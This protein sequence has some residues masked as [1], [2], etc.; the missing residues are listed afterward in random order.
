[1]LWDLCMRGPDT[2][3]WVQEIFLPDLNIHVLIIKKWKGEKHFSNVQQIYTI[4]RYDW[5]SQLC[6]KL[7]LLWN[8]SLTKFRPQWDSN[9]WPLWDT[10]W[11]AP[12]WLHG[13]VGRALHQHHRGHGF[14]SHSGLNFFR[15]RLHNC[16]NWVHNCDDQS[17]LHIILDSIVQ[18]YEISYIHLCKFIPYKTAVLTGYYI[19][20][21]MFITVLSTGTGLFL[22]AIVT[23]FY[24]NRYFP[25][26]LSQQSMYKN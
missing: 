12:R 11:P 22:K 10:Y 3:A 8:K 5:S 15:L 9:P 25:N 23:C 20:V 26:S 14:E 1:M 16:L 19:T 17:Y 4:Q 13:S 6:P 21:V 7:T 18:I 2:A 24:G